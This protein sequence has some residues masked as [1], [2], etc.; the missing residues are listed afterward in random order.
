MPGGALRKIRSIDYAWAVADTLTLHIDPETAAQLRQ[1]A[2]E[3][4][5]TVE[6]AAERL[7]AYLTDRSRPYLELSEEDLADLDE[8]LKD[9]GPY[10]TPEEAEAFLVRFKV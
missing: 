2:S 10:A 4:G 3:T 7:L 1:L 5:E 6:E 8:R 9:P